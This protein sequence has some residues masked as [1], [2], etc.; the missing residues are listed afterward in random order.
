[1]PTINALPLL[2]KTMKLEFWDIVIILLIIMI[3]LLLATTFLYDQQSLVHEALAW[4]GLP[5]F[6]SIWL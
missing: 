5:Q 2:R 4:I 6:W 1:M 3:C